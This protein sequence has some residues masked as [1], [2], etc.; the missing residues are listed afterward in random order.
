[1]IIVLAGFRDVDLAHIQIMLT[2]FT[3]VAGILAG[4]ITGQA[5]VQHLKG[6]LKESNSTRTKREGPGETRTMS[7]E[8]KAKHDPDKPILCRLGNSM[9]GVFSARD[10]S[11]GSS[12]DVRSLCAA[13]SF[14]R[15][16]RGVQ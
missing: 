16:L 15:P 8:A 9:G 1:M 2:V 12:T 7:V 13:G 3:T 4:F 6:G 10:G 14:V 11:R 5:L